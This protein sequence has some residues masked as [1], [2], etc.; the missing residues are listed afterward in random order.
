VE[1]IL[2]ALSIA[3]KAQNIIVMAVSVFFGII[4]G[5]IP[6]LGPLIAIVIF[7]PFSFSFPAETGI[8]SLLGLFIGGVY[9]GA[10]TSITLGIPGTPAAA[11]TVLDGYPMSQKGE[12]GKAIALA[13]TASV[14]GGIVSVLV[15][16]TVAPLLARVALK[17][18]P[19]EY[20]MLAILGLTAIASVSR[21]STIKGLISGILGLLIMT[22]GMDMFTA[23]ERFTFGNPELRGGIPYIATLVGIFAV[24]RVMVFLEE[25]AKR[26]LPPKGLAPRFPKLKEFKR[27]T[28]TYIKSSILGTGIGA[29][30]GV[31]TAIASFISYAEARRASKHPE[32]FGTGVPEGIVAAEAANNAVTGGALIPMLTLAIPGDPTTAVLMGAFFMHGLLPGPRLFQEHFHV[33]QGFFIAMLVGNIVMLFLGMY[34]SRL[35][36]HA[37]KIEKRILI[38]IILVMCFIGAYSL[39][40]SLFDILIMWIFGVIGYIMRKLRIPLAPMVLGLVLSPLVEQSLRRSLTI[41]RGSPW[42]FFTRPISI[43]IIVGIIFL[44]FWPLLSERRRAIESKG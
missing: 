23:Y 1:S 15:L 19:P 6:G 32:K 39:H 14:F 26:L 7:M 37:L 9:G 17:F 30:P 11:A 33:I 22:I 3:L 35:F 36:L 8:I 29:L 2:P 16:M 31:G 41:S 20:T 5:I 42:I 44:L 21:E 28:G 24:S 12:T 25:E 40:H 43:G 34:G 27:L 18:G 4:A 13:T 38:P 10:I